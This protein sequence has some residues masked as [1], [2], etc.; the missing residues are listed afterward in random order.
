M[1]SRVD[2]GMKSCSAA[3][4]NEQRGQQTRIFKS[5]DAGSFPAIILMEIQDEKRKKA[6]SLSL[7]RMR[8]V[9]EKFEGKGPVKVWHAGGGGKWRVYFGKPGGYLKGVTVD[10]TR[11]AIALAKSRRIL[12]NG[13][14]T[15][16]HLKENERR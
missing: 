6:L 13:R 2:R 15:P 9:F 4:M 8:T 11:K 3:V 16:R 7:S 14:S 1:N 12:M 10:P 5:Q